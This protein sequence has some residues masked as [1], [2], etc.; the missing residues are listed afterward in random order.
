MLQFKDRD[1]TSSHLPWGG[2]RVEYTL[3]VS[4]S[5]LRNPN[6]SKPYHVYIWR[7]QKATMAISDEVKQ[8]YNNELGKGQAL[9]ATPH[10]KVTWTEIQ[11]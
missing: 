6:Q 4:T 1:K 2:F 7:V 5:G 9:T 11:V 10:V 8:I 3:D